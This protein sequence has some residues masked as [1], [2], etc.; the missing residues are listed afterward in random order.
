MKTFEG[1]VVSSRM[2]R[3]VTVLIERKYRHP[4]YGKILTKRRKIHARDEL[5]AKIGQ[6]VKIVEVRPLAKTISFKVTE[7]LSP[8]AEPKAEKP[9]AK[10]REVKAK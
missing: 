9:V 6:W 4:L 2:N 10:K 5:G 1:K 8:K 3:T 7:I